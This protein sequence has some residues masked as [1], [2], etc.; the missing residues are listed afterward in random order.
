M[1]FI[2]GIER[3]ATTWVSNL[4]EAHPDT[5][6]FVEPVSIY[7]A[8][9]NEWPDRFEHITDLEEKAIYFLSEFCRVRE[10]KR[11]LFTNWFDTKYA[12][13]F[14]L[15]LSNF[16]VRKQI[17]SEAATDFAAINFHRKTQLSVDK[18]NQPK[19]KVIKELRLN[20]NAQILFEIDPLA[21]AVVVVR[22]P[23]ANVQSIQ[24][25]FKKGNLAELKPLLLE[26]YGSVNEV[27]I[28]KY[29]RDSYNSLFESLEHSSISSLVISHTQLLRNPV[30]QIKT[31]GKFAGLSNFEIML[32]YLSES[33]QEGQGLHNTN[34]SHRELLA[35][36]QKAKDEIL[37]SLKKEFRNT[38]FHPQL[39]AVF[40]SL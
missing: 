18:S 26:H 29:W 7:S 30:E 9:F 38:D 19:L 6:V 12:W 28:Y 8:H 15:W 21:R 34:R 39:R 25:Q 13:K 40:N 14:D 16:L 35:Q 5:E 37:P 33:N 2:L 20:F 23:F 17:A 3:A 11:W 4:L 31:L 32:D 1:L 10:H 24:K 27:S 22:N 36:N